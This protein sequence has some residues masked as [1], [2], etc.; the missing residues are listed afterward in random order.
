MPPTRSGAASQT[1]LHDRAAAVT[2]AAAR[3]GYVSGQ[4][5]GT[6]LGLCTSWLR[7][8]ARTHPQAQARVL[9]PVEASRTPRGCWG[10]ANPQANLCIYAQPHEDGSNARPECAQHRAVR[11]NASGGQ[12][13]LCPARQPRQTPDA[14]NVDDPEGDGLAARTDRCRLGAACWLRACACCRR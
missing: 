2:C 13:L 10:W 12:A 3:C 11:P 1:L 8:R 9:W 6:S 14:R 5:H 7:Q 4:R